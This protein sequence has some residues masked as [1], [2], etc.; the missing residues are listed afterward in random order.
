VERLLVQSVLADKNKQYLR[1]V[2]NHIETCMEDVKSAQLDCD[3]L[4]DQ[5]EGYQD[6]RMNDTLY[7]LT[8]VTTCIIPMQTLTGLY[9]MNFVKADG[10]PNMPE[11]TWQYGYAGFWVI[12]L[13]LTAVLLLIMQSKFGLHRGKVRQG[14]LRE[15]DDDVSLHQRP[16]R[17][18][19]VL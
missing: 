8:L 10:D 4:L 5:M 12:S 17:N 3:G 16:A 14:R 13:I 18:A 7:F 9:G 1:D 19:P 2:D 15:H 6:K 11:L